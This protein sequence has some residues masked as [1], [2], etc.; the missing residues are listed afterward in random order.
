MKTTIS[1]KRLVPGLI[2]GPA[3]WLGPYIVMNSLFLPALIQ[4]L[5]APHKIELVALF[6]TCGMIV[7]AISNMIAGA[8]SDKTK[9]RFGKRAP[10]IMG[11]AFVFMLAMMAASVSP[12]V[13][14]LLAAWMVGQAALNFIVAPMVAW[15]DFAP[16]DGR[17]TASSAYGGLGMALGNNGF[18]VIGAMFLSQFRL[19]FVIFG[20]I[21]F[22]GVLI[23]V[24]IVH[25]PSNVDDV[26]APKQ[27]KP[28]L[29]LK[30]AKA[31]FPGWSV[32]RDYYLALMGKLFQGVGNFAITGY[33]LYIMTDFL[34]RGSQ[35]QSSIQLINL[36]MLIFGIFM[37]FVAGPV[38]DK[39]K[40]LKYP[41]G[42]STIFL[43][44]GALALFFL[45]DNIG[46][47]IYAF[48]AGIGMGMWN[49]LD[50]LLNLE[51]IPDQN[52]VAFFLGVY[53]LG[54]TVTQAIAPV[55]A[56]AVISLFGFSAIFLFSF[57]FSLIGGILMLS[58]KSVKR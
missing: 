6:S 47:I 49:S 32:G 57:V 43:A 45:R 50:N 12:T 51:V 29:T 27:P 55:I 17:G 37:G 33:I 40:I 4:H 56:A 58:I 52:R 7:A 31:I 3:S 19:G 30:D 26:D 53:N 22:V 34:H 13:P 48:A 18:N 44:F 14:V 42:F 36:I 54:N 2:I 8:L 21:A 41:V 16:K 20:I 1:L 9:S 39:F 24:L 38:S 28:K 35:T 46:I 25:E 23:A 11:G 15:I 5:D 10:W